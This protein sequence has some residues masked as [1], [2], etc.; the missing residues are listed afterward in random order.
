VGSELLAR[1]RGVVKRLAGWWSKKWRQFRCNH[2]CAVRGPR[3]IVCKHG[4]PKGVGDWWWCE[5]CGRLWPV[6]Y[7]YL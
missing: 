7:Y 3:T 6:R 2:C 1:G 4:D 5:D